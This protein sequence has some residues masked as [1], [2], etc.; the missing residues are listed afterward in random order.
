M[1]KGYLTEYMLRAKIRNQ[2]SKFWVWVYHR[3][4][5]KVKW[6]SKAIGFD[7]P[8]RCKSLFGVIVTQH[9]RVSHSSS[10]G[11]QCRR[12]SGWKRKEEVGRDLNLQRKL[13]L[14]EYKREGEVL[15]P[16]R[17]FFLKD[18]I[19]NFWIWYFQQNT[20]TFHRNFI[21]SGG[22]SYFILQ[23]INLWLYW[24]MK[25]NLYSNAICFVCGC[26]SHRWV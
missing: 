13:K 22:S 15:P 19:F 2:K 18:F 7:A 1:Y 8:S 3:N 9:L 23:K 4:Y 24:T 25:R 10:L 12:F 21:Y 20:A 16:L 11:P 17:L 14:Y 26:L 5:G 6:L